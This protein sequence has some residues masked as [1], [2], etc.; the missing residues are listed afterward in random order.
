MWNATA[1]VSLEEKKKVS[2]W[3][4]NHRL[5][6]WLVAL[7]IYVLKLFQDHGQH[8]KFKQEIA[9]TNTTIK[10]QYVGKSVKRKGEK[11][12]PCQATNLWWIKYWAL[13]AARR[14]IQIVIPPLI[15]A[16][17]AHCTGCKRQIGQ[18][19]LSVITELSIPHPSLFQTMNFSLMPRNPSATSRC[20]LASTGGA[21]ASTLAT[22]VKGFIKTAE[23]TGNTF[24]PYS[25]R[26]D[27]FFF[28]PP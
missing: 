28:L 25:D 4:L 12:N 9:W 15:Q 18:I 21:C 19:V 2:A 17:W 26:S 5:A 1:T 10:V 23:S 16:D 27:F 11:K 6:V 24:C 20:N 14:Q 22:N 13:P 7:V 3:P 8:T